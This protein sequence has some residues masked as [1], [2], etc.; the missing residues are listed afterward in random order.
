MPLNLL[1]QVTSR[2]T[3]LSTLMKH[4][5]VACYTI[6][7]IKFSKKFSRDQAFLI[8]IYLMLYIQ[9]KKL[10]AFCQFFFL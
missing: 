5:L 2:L 4:F 6:R 7:E 1:K 8:V 3:A 10:L 9:Q